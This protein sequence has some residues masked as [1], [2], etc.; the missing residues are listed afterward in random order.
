MSKST[1]ISSQGVRA[2]SHT[3][4][5]DVVAG[6]IAQYQ[7]E[8]S[9]ESNFTQLDG[10]DQREALSRAADTVRGIFE[11]DYTTEGKSN[12]A[13]VDM[14]AWVLAI[15]QS[16]REYM[17]QY[18]T[19]SV[20]PKGRMAS[21]NINP[22]Y[23][24]V[25]TTESFDNQELEKYRHISLNVNYA[26]GQQMPSMEA[27]Y[28]TVPV[29]PDSAG[30]EVDFHN[31]FIQNVLERD[32]SGSPQDF[33]YR[34]LIDVYRDSS[35]LS[36]GGVK[37]VP[38]HNS[39]TAKHFVDTAVVAPFTTVVGN[40][41]VVTSYLKVNNEVD[42]IAIGHLDKAERAGAADF[43]D[44]LDRSLGIE[45]L[46]QEFG[47]IALNWD[48]LDQ[49]GSRFVTSTEHGRRRLILDYVLASLQLD[50]DSLFDIHGDAIDHPAAT[51]IRDRNLRVRMKVTINGEADVE[52][53]VASINPGSVSVVAIFGADGRPLKITGD[54][55]DASLKPILDFVAGSKITGYTPD[56]RLTNSNHRHLGMMLTHRSTREVLVTKTRAPFFYAYP[57]NEERSDVISGHLATAAAAY[58]HVEGI[59]HMI[60]VHGRIMSQTGGVRGDL[61]YGNF[62]DNLLSVEG[63][64]RNLVNTYVTTL[65]VNVNKMQSTQ[66]V[67]DIYNANEVL[68]NALRHVALDIKQKSG[69]EV[70]ARVLDGSEGKAKWKFAIV[71]SERIKTFMNL[72][73][74]SRLLGAD[75]EYE[76]YGDT[77]ELLEDVIYMGIVR[78]T[79]GIDI[80]SNG[81]CLQ[82]PTMVSHVTSW[83]YGRKSEELLVQPRFN[84]YQLLPIMVRFDVTGVE[85]V[86]RNVSPF[87]VKLAAEGTGD[88]VVPGPVVPPAPAPGGG[89]VDDGSGTDPVV[90]TP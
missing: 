82:S 40:R 86:L 85:E 57:D 35:I 31:L 34:R 83:R 25:Y 32:L 73:G 78:E 58:T 2:S 4:S 16:G 51:I 75:I 80:L 6:A 62:E 15:G 49:P 71:T 24:S 67:N 14:A 9:F 46:L 89:G 76:V 22:G 90:P 19:E 3:L 43:T 13:G 87:L 23:E 21:L 52:K 11:G 5:Q 74:D 39:T 68:L 48:V 64:G 1:I 17:A 36:D 27:M 47:S 41:S 69:Y 63:I 84:H 72:K 59:K 10:G 26:L 7:T 53:G 8:T 88:P 66:T 70:A 65:P 60:G 44:A 55:A 79:D 33:G 29:T 45:S 50:K 28:R 30:I 12:K 56:S 37:I 38:T 77:S 42:L 54:D 20:T 18:T 81:V 61:T